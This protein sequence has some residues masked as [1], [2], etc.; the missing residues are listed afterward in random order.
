MIGFVCTG[1]ILPTRTPRGNLEQKLIKDVSVKFSRKKEIAYIL[2]GRSISSFR[3]AVPYS[4]CSR[5]VPGECLHDEL[6]LFGT[7]TINTR[8]CARRLKKHVRKQLWFQFSTSV[9]CVTIEVL[10][11]TNL[12]KKVDESTEMERKRS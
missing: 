8:G 2:F 11:L 12:F 7:K 5:N 1:R 9:V 6:E 3:P 4:C 10:V